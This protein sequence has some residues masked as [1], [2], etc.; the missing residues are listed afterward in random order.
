M[1][2]LIFSTFV[3]CLLALAVPGARAGA[4]TASVEELVAQA[5]AL[6]A[7]RA[8]LARVDEALQSLLQAS[9]LDPGRYDVNWRLAKYSYYLAAHT[10]DKAARKAAIRQGIAAGERAV[11]AQPERPEGHFWLG[12]NL[13]ERARTQGA[14]RALGTVGDVRREMEAVLKIDE[15][16]QN[17]SAFMVLAQ[18]DL[19]LPGFVGGD[20]KRAVERLE[21]G[22]AYGKQNAFLRLRLAEAYL[23]V[24]NKQEARRQIE[25]ILAMKPDPNYIPEYKEAATEARKLL[26]E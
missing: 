17:G 18:I 19:E 24:K 5:D 4:H 12:A 16:Y 7:R 26:Q 21:R 6:Y 10:G 20:K 8:E 9:Q 23:A 14:L 2:K 25:A 1:T 22:L 11:Q 3:F 13:G 15:G